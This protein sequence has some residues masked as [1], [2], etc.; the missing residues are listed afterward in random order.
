M[1]E[2]PL[3][4][5]DD[6]QESQKNQDNR[7][8]WKGFWISIICNVI[9]AVIFLCVL[10]LPFGYAIGSHLLIVGTLLFLINLLITIYLY[11]K[12]QRAF[13]GMVAGFAVGFLITLITGVLLGA[14]C[15]NIIENI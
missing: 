2:E 12:N 15:F 6:T 13:Q 10:P 3:P 11:F 9:V 5:E 7:N 4:T 14:I 8:F 1:N